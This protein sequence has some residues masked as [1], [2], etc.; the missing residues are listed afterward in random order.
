MLQ[1]PN[2]KPENCY[3]SALPTG[4][5][6]CLPCYTRWLGTGARN[7]AAER[8]V[9]GGLAATAEPAPAT[10]IRADDEGVLLPNRR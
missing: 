8:D 1:N 3:C 5:G 9:G 7:K 2:E 10:T 6:L 4:S